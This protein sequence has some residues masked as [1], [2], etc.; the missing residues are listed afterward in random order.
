MTTSEIALASFEAALTGAV[1][2]A[3]PSIVRVAR[4]RGGGSG[5]AWSTDLVVTSSFHTPD[6]THVGV[7]RADSAELDDRDGVVIGR[8][9]GTD[10]AV[11]RVEGGL[12]PATFRE[13][14][15]A[16]GLPTLALGRPG[17]SVRA[18]F[19]VLGV[20]G[21]ALRTPSGGTVDRYLESDRLIPRG[22]AGGPLV[23]LDGRVLGMNTRTLFRGAD[24]AVPHATLRRVVDE[25]V[26]HGGVRR[27]YLGVG[28]YPI[29]LPAALAAAFGQERAAL[30]ASVEDGGA[31]ASA[32]V[33]VGDILVTLDGV[34]IGGPD[35]LRDALL[36]RAGKAVEVVIIRAGARHA[37]SVSVGTRS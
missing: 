33:L 35:E 18:S 12:T 24:L 32:G 19:R 27:G 1:S 17:R 37:V 28:A 36:D 6:R 21:P 20:V 30:V 9:P 14:G 34:A 2:T 5:I 13:D 31:A 8:D 15:L 26:A 23:S 25:I 7:A 10:I 16:V 22:F 4:P 11:V 3:A 29:G